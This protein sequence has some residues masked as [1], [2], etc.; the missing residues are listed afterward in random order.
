[1]TGSCTE[2]QLAK[3]CQ[4]GFRCIG[5]LLELAAP[6]EETRSSGFFGGANVDT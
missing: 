4:T 2:G 3:F 1:M 5:S 6:Q